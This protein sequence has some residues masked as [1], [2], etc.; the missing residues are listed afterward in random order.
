MGMKVGELFADLDVR[1]EKFNKGVD[2]A[3][4]SL[5]SKLGVSS[6]AVG[7]ATAGMAA[8]GAAAVAA[9]A[10]GVKEFASFEKGMREV[11]TL[12]P[13]AS[14]E[15]KQELMGDIREFS[16]EMGVATNESVPALYQAISAGVPEDN[17]FDFLETAQKAAV[18][19]VTDL[20]TSVDGLSSVVNAYGDDVISA[21]EASDLM[22]TAVKEGKT[23]FEE[24]SSTLYNVLPS[25]SSLG[26]EF[27]DVT[28]AIASMTA[29]G[30]PTAQATTQ[31]RQALNE[32]SK[33]GSDAATVFEQMAGQ[34]FKSFIKEGGNMQ[35]AFAVM[36]KAA[37]EQDTSVKNLFGS[38][39]A[40]QAVMALTGKGAEGFKENLDE[41]GNSA[42]A[43]ED[44]YDEME[45]SLSRSFDKLKAAMGEVWLTVGE[46]LAP[47]VK[48]FADWLVENMPMIKEVVKTTFKI[49]ERVIRGLFDPIGTAKSDL[50]ALFEVFASAYDVFVSPFEDTKEYL[51]DFSLFEIGQDIIQG[52]I[53][54]L[55]EKIGAPVRMIKGMAADVKSAAKNILGISS[56]SK[57]FE[58]YGKNIT[59]GLERGIANTERDV[60]SRLS[61]MLESMIPQSSPELAGAGG[62]PQMI[63]LTANYYGIDNET[64]EQA[65]TDLT[66]KLQGRGIGGSFR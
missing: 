42:G 63:Y 54:G 30:T 43:T 11:F 9:G 49:I 61:S 66:S 17:V 6:A 10:K 34:S 18:G 37:E 51:S 40:G 31:I 62:G 52:L 50:E 19:G 29:Q 36:E 4:S 14:G 64:A 28:A 2:S 57:V 3:R 22:F 53:D 7:A 35:E 27:E 21:E 15:M 12:V 58:G 16:T 38:I 60:A 32:L 26:V 8:V 59:A 48:D 46:E 41:M 45:Q 44:A 55:K 39:E 23:T 56:P 25:A 13:E 1:D 24:M 47:L 20:T 65:N 5:I 33:D